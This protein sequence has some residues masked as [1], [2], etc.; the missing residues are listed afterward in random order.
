MAIFQTQAVTVDEPDT[1]RSTDLKMETLPRMICIQQ[2]VTF[3]EFWYNS[4]RST[5]YFAV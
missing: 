2:Q 3:Q 4:Y 5:P 1:G